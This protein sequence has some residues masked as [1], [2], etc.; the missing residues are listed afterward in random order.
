MFADY[1][2]IKVGDVTLKGRRLTLKEIHAH[3]AEVL[4]GQLSAERSVEMIREH[5]TLVDGTPI[6]PMDMTPGQVRQVVSEMVLPAEG[7]GIADFIGL[8]S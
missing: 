3:Y 5:V 2:T 7:R 8:L 1:F 4:C 6:D